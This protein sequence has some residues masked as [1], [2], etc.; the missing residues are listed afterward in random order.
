MVD[1]W[2]GSRHAADARGRHGSILMA[3]HDTLI[4][5]PKALIE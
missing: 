2:C 3:R 4:A 1:R 5:R